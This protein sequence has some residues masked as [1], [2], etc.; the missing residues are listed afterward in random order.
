MKPAVRKP[1]AVGVARRQQILDA[2]HELFSIRGYRGA[3]MRDVAAQVGLSMAGLL[4]YF[5]SKEDLL[6]G[7]LKHRDDTDTPW[8][9]EKWAET[10]NIREALHAL[11]ARNMAQPEIVRLFVTLSAEATDPDHPAHDYFQRRYR[12]S[13]ELF[14][15]VITKAQE[16][17]EL[18]AA[19][20]GPLLVA[21]FDGLQI[22]WL[23]EP[24]FDLVAQV[25]R[26]LDT[27]TP[28][29]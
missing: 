16:R 11:I 4:H 27:I 29:P 21:L 2:A 22:Q 25:D 18:T 23:L 7:V 12:H 9:E 28:S 20:D 26:H 1:Y 14:T 5:P 8:F 6:Q 3:S 13:R 17:G 24:G 19:A 10:G 15:R